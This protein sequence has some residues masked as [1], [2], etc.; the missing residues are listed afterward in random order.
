MV[1]MK[2]QSHGMYTVCHSICWFWIHLSGTV[3]FLC[4]KDRSAQANI[5]DSDQMGQI[6]QGLLCFSIPSAF[7]GGI[8]L[9]YCLFV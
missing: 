3:N 5:V 9:K 8:Y 1:N 2:E 6:D 4:F 7:W